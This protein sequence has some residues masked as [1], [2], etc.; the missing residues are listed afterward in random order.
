[1]RLDYVNQ[2]ILQTY[3]QCP[4]L[5]KMRKLGFKHEQKKKVGEFSPQKGWGDVTTIGKAIHSVLPRYVEKGKNSALRMLAK[6][7]RTAK[8]WDEARPLFE[9]LT[10]IV[11]VNDG[12][13]A[14]ETLEFRIRGLPVCQASVDFI[15]RRNGAVEVIELKTGWKLRGKVEIEQDIEARWYMFML[16]NLFPNVEKRLKYLFLRHE[17]WVDVDPE[18]LDLFYVGERVGEIETDKQFLPNRA[19]CPTC[20]YI[21]HCKIGLGGDSPQEIAGQYLHYKAK[22][23]AY[24]ELLKKRVTEPVRLG[25]WGFYWA[26]VRNYKILDRNKFV[27]WLME[28]KIGFKPDMSDLKKKHPGLVPRAVSNGLLTESDATRFTVVKG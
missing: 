9:R 20:E 25:N 19:Y 7:V 15:I 17:T 28:A 10:E 2:T 12:V 22:A 5:F 26:K 8:Q 11:S 6:Q 27:D 13:K 16:N 1:M 18:P 14:E 21:T 24:L 4:H 23:D 3:A